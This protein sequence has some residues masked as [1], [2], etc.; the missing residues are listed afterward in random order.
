MYPECRHIMPSGRKC[1]SP[2]LRSQA[3]CYY[4]TRVHRLQV[5]PSRSAGEPAEENLV[6]PV[7]EDRCSMQLALAQVLNALGS[8]R[9]D[10]RRAGLLLYG[11]QIASQNVDRDEAILPRN[12]V[13]IVTYTEDGEETGPEEEERPD[14]A[15]LAAALRARLI[16][17]L[18]DSSGPSS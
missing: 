9:L 15:S 17:R 2:A 7:I 18:V 6:F 12:A 13:K 16:E 1:T 14:H 11:L 10:P 4:H 3:F 5:R 8:S